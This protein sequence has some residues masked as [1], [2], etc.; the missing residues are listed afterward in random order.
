M[1]Y[2]S[3]AS[4]E[5]QTRLLIEWQLLTVARPAEAAAARWEEIDLDAETWTIPAGR[6]KMRRDHVIPLCGQAMAVLETMEPIQPQEH[7]FFP[8]LK[9]Q[10]C[11]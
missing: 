2:L 4:I 7:M 3:V 11:Q 5:R 1:H 8:A 6:M 9:I 10:C